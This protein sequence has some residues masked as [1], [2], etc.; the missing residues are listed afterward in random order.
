MGNIQI[1]LNAKCKLGMCNLFFVT[2]SN[3]EGCLLIGCGTAKIDDHGKIHV[4][5]MVDSLI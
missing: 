4:V 3:I 2:H 5:E 1:E